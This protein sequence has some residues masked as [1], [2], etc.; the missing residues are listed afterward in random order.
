MIAI[1]SQIRKQI[2]LSCCRKVQKFSNIYENYVYGELEEFDNHHDFD[3]RDVIY[4]NNI[5]YAPAFDV[6]KNASLKQII[7]ESKVVQQTELIFN[8]HS[9]SEKLARPMQIIGQKRKREKL[10][11]FIEMND[12]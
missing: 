5:L 12:L 8:N 4:P 1:A 10:P 11:E 3:E 2:Q 6:D 9:F 7:N